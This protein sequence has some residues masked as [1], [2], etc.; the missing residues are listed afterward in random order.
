[1]TLYLAISKDEYKL[2]LAVA[3]SVA[4]LSRM[5]GAKVNTIHCAI[6]KGYE[7]F[8]RVIIEDEEGE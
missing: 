7:T 4:E 3:D 6:K 5:T 2:P 1:M 8:E